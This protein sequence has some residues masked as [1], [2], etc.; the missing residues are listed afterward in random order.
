MPEHGFLFEVIIFLAAA[1]V[2]VLLSR[3]LRASPVLGYLVAGIVIGP[4]G[5]ALVGDAETTRGLAELGIAFLLF[6]IGLELSWKRLGLLRMQIFGLGS[7]QFLVSGLAIG[8]VTFALGASVEAAVIV[9]GGL[10]LSSTAIVL[11][12]LSERGEIAS[13]MGRITFSILR[14]VT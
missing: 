12:I 8:A 5:V 2:F 3:R 11:Q 4:H 9:G 1:V 13:R 10:A 14:A 6:S 7:A